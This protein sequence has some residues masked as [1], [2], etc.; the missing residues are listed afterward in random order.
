[1]QLD[2]KKVWFKSSFGF[3]KP[4]VWFKVVNPQKYVK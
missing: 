4:D 3:G 2:A 1:M